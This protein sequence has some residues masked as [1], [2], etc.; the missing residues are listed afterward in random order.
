MGL[1]VTSVGFLMQLLGMVDTPLWGRFG[2]SLKTS[3]VNQKHCLG[4][5]SWVE[6]CE[7]I[8]YLLFSR[9]GEAG[10]G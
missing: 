5:S 9:I 10:V 6:N 2:T 8:H 1:V 3:S 7:D 4:V